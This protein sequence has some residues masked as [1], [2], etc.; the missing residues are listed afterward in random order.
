MSRNAVDVYPS[1]KD[2]FD[3]TNQQIN[4]GVGKGQ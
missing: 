3:N 1:F 2:G 4:R